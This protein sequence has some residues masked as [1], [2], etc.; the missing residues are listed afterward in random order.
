MGGFGV[1]Y[2]AVIC[3][4]LG[5][6]ERIVF[7]QITTTD[8]V[9]TAWKCSERCPVAN[10]YYCICD[11]EKH[12]RPFLMKDSIFN[13]TAVAYMIGHTAGKMG[14]QIEDVPECF[15]QIKL[16]IEEMPCVVLANEYGIGFE[17]L[18]TK[19]PLHVEQ[20]CLWHGREEKSL[21]RVLIKMLSR[22]REIYGVDY[23]VSNFI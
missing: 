13:D 4:D 2:R 20:P 23:D 18:D 19:E 7:A 9:N 11:K 21:Y 14:Y 12:F 10:S 1:K 15:T 5:G 16:Y 8:P 22:I 3:Y 6:G 17:D